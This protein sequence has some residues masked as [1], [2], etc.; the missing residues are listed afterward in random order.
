MRTLHLAGL[1]FLLLLSLASVTLYLAGLV[2]HKIQHT[3][4]G[5]W[6]LAG[7]FATLAYAGWL[8][9]RITHTIKETK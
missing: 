1:F 5:G 8:A 3:T 4:A 2:I 6:E 7:L 9:A